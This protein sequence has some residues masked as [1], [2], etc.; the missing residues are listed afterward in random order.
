VAFVEM[1]LSTT[2][3]TPTNQPINRS[4]NLIG[5]SRQERCKTREEKNKLGAHL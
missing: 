4:T 5:A 2:K 1:E 3:Q